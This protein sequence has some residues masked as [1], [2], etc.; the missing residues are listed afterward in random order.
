MSG[1]HVVRERSEPHFIDVLDRVLDKGIVIAYDIDISVAGLHAVEIT[2][3][4]IIASIETYRRMEDASVVEALRSPALSGATDE[5]LR[6]MD[7]A[8]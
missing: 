8:H 3:R 7:H 5:F 2:G 1:G 6:R 4:V